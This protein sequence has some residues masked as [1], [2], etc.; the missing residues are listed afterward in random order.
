MCVEGSRE[1]SPLSQFIE[2][3]NE[4]KGTEVP[5]LVPRGRFQ[6]MGA[7]EIR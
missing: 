2:G 6:F 1:F 7:A 3:S 5:F 4:W